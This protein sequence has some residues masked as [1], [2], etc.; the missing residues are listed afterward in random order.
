MLNQAIIK[1]YLR[2][3]LIDVRFIESDEATVER[4]LLIDELRAVFVVSWQIV[5]NEANWKPSKEQFKE[6]AAAL[7]SLRSNKARQLR[8]NRQGVGI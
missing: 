3:G 7:Y 5:E 2:R 8:G 4:R 1:G 6:A